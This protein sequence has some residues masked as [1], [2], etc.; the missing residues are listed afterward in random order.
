MYPELDAPTDSLDVMATKADWYTSSKPDSGSTLDATLCIESGPPPPG[1]VSSALGVALGGA[2]DVPA[3][4]AV[5][6]AV[7]S[8]ADSWFKGKRVLVVDDGE[9]FDMMLMML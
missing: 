4:R 8:A 9:G 1:V 7:D 6:S 5:D 2:E 3:M